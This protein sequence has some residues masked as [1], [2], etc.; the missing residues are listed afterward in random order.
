[1]DSLKS[2]FGRRLK[3][4]RL[5]R[6]L[7]QEE[8]AEATRLSAESISNLERG[9][10]APKFETLEVLAQALGVSVKALFE[11]EASEI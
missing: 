3:Q 7:T 10:H 11:F 4:L 9:K 2:R 8:L 5:Y 1:M 6:G